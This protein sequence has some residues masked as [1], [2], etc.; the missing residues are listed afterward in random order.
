MGLQPAG[1]CL[2]CMFGGEGFYNTKMTGPGQMIQSMSFPK[3]VR[4][5]VPPGSAAGN[6]ASMAGDIAGAAAGAPEDQE[7]MTR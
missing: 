1:G 7:E 6:A 4:A 2:G 5:I 3:F